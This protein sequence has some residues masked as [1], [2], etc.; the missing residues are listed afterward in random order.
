[1]TTACRCGHPKADHQPAP[2]TTVRTACALPCRCPSYTPRPTAV[3]A[4]LWR[5][6]PA[7]NPAYP[8]VE[9]RR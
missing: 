9:A 8:A 2:R 3:R 7:N 1:M 4:A 6:L 5:A